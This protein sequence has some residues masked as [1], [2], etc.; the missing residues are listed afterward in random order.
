[1]SDQQVCINEEVTFGDFCR[2]EE[3][4]VNL[5]LNGGLEM[6]LINY[7][8][9]QKKLESFKPSEGSLYWKPEPGKYKVKALSELEEAD[10]YKEEGKPDKPQSQIKLEIN[11][12]E[13]TWTFSLG[14]SLASTYG[15]LVKLAT[16]RGNQLIGTEFVVV[17]VS[18]GSKNAYTIVG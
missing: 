11:G 6:S 4:Y 12:E 9:E 17:V 3:D 16:E 10:P 14:K 7:A 8:E 2:L 5:N 18:D 1:M 15:Q 13:K